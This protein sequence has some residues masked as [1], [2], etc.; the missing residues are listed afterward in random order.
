MYISEPTLCATMSHLLIC[1]VLAEE[2]PNTL[3]VTAKKKKV[4]IFRNIIMRL[5]PGDISTLWFLSAAT[6]KAGLKLY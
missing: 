5:S 1:N 2:T 4:C 3:Q 6:E